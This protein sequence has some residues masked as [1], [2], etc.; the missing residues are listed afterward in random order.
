MIINKKLTGSDHFSSR[1]FLNSG[2]VNTPL[3]DVSLRILL[4][5]IRTI[6]SLV[7][8]LVAILARPIRWWNIG[9][10]LPR[11]IL[12]QRNHVPLAK[13]SLRLILLLRW[14]ISDVGSRGTLLSFCHHRSFRLRSTC[15]I[16]SFVALGSSINVI[17]VLITDKLIKSCTLVVAHRLHQL[18]AKSPLEASDLL[19]IYVHKFRGIP[20]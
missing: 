8:R 13:T 17:V 10:V 19:G 1:N 12:G 4:G 2:I 16:I 7:T 14:A 18:R 5:R 11:S 3:T 20:H 9:T 6:I 15:L